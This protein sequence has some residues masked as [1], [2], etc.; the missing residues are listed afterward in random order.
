MPRA[1]KALGGWLAKR[2][3][4]EP[5]PATAGTEVRVDVTLNDAEVSVDG[6]Y[7]FSAAAVRGSAA[8]VVVRGAKVDAPGGSG[9]GSVLAALYRVGAALLDRSTSRVG[10]VVFKADGCAFA[11]PAKRVCGAK[12]AATLSRAA[13]RA[14]DASRG[15]VHLVAPS[16]AVV[17]ASPGG[18]TRV[19]AG[20]HETPRNVVRFPTLERPLSR[21]HRFWLLPWDR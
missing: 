3:A 8:P 12:K 19:A 1:R 15:P 6:L 18:V 17:E 10:D 16:G 13:P 5:L 20:V 7:D 9:E 2:E 4:S 21:S 11:S 14:V